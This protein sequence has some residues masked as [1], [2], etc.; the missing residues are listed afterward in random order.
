MYSFFPKNANEI[1]T[2][3][4]DFSPEAREEVKSLFTFL[5]QKAPTVDTPINID[6]K[7]NVVNI[8]RA[9]AG[10][11]ELSDIVKGAKLSRIK[12][13]YGNGSSGNRGVNNRGNLFEG[14]FATALQAWWDGEEVSD[15]KILAAIEDIDKTYNLRASKTLKIEVVGGENTKRPIQFG[16]TIVLSNPKGS[17]FDVGKSLTDVTL[18]TDSQEIYL[19]LKLGGTTTFFN[20][21]VRTIL[22]PPELKSGNISNKNGLKLLSIFG[23]DPIRFCQIF[24]GDKLERSQFIDRRA[25]YDS[26]A[27]G[28][29][30][31]SGIG[32]NYHVIHKLSSKILSKKM[33]A[34]AM[35]KAANITSGITV[36][37]GG[38]GGNGKRIDVEFES[39]SYKFKINIRDTQGADGY[40]TRMM[41][42][43]NHK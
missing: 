22:T 26:A 5:K 8:S 18:T 1:E 4:K 32:Y 41:C 19:S 9:L 34:A 16:S 31:Q 40:P 36:Y 24:N 10:S 11:V 29:L 2:T 7:K 35:K 6:L 15:K 39:S 28:K 37:Y 25:K 17:G 21:G 3:L 13:K 43:F 23:I 14:I 30:L 12:I 27:I 38:K 42:D 33:D 20:V